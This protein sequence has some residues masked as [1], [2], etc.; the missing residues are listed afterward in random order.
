MSDYQE[1][2]RYTSVSVCAPAVRMV[3][4]QTWAYT[5]DDG[6]LTGDHCIHPVVAI[7]SAG[8]MCC[9]YSATSV[10]GTLTVSTL[11]M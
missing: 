11:R 3:A 6:E 5:E 7:E 4:I 8:A 2:T 9:V 10:A 1:H